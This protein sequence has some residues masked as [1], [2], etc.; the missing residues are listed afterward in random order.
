MSLNLCVLN[1]F[2]TND[3]LL[4]KSIINFTHEKLQ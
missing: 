4:G 2:E 3:K 1:M